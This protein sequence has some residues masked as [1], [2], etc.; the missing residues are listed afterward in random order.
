MKMTET[1]WTLTTPLAILAERS[2][3]LDVGRVASRA[4]L[5]DIEASL[6][7]QTTIQTPLQSALVTLVIVEKQ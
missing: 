6:H 1:N 3:I 7:L 2:S 5:E 4:V